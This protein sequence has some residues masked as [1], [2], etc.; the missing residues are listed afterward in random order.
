MITNLHTEGM[1][2]LELD[3][4]SAKWDLDIDT[5]DDYRSIFTGLTHE[6]VLKIATK[7]IYA[8]WCHYPDQADDRARELADDIPRTAMRIAKQ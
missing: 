7:M 4:Q 3:E 5:Y 2:D 8:V 6:E 1:T